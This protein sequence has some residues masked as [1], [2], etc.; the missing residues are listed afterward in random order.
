MPEYDVPHAAGVAGHQTEEPFR[1]GKADLLEMRDTKI[2][3]WVM[4]E[5]H[6]G[7]V[8][9]LAEAFF[10]PRHPGV[11]EAAAAPA[12]LQR[13]EE[14]D[15]TRV[16]RVEHR[17]NEPL[18][19]TRLIRELGHE[20]LAVVVIAEKEPHGHGQA[21]QFGGKA[22]IGLRF[23]PVGEVTRDDREVSVRMTADH[24]VDDRREASSRVEAMDRRV[25]RDEVGVGDV[26][27]LHR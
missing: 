13:V 20:G 17:L 10:Q 4:H 16:S 1:V 27:D 22:F 12:L 25:S 6:H 15:P 18:C 26:D 7:P 9:R 8:A 2:E 11:A 23:A 3:G 24:V 14:D 19:V 5:D 21:G